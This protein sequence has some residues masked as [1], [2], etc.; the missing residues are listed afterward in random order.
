[1]GNGDY[2]EARKSLDKALA[3]NPTHKYARS[4]LAA[5]HYIRGDKGDFAA[6]E[7]EI[8][9]WDPTYGRLYRVVSELVGERQRRYDVAAEFA[10]KAL[11]IDSKDRFAYTLLGE[12]LMNLGQTDEALEKFDAGYKA[13]KTYKDVRR[14][15]WRNVLRDVIPNFEIIE[16]EH[17]RI[18]MPRAE[19]RIMR[20]Y[21]PDLLEESYETLGKKYGVEATSPTFVD[22]FDRQDDFSVRSIGSAGLPALGVC[23]GRVVTLLGPTAM[24]IGNFSWSRTT[25][26]E[27]AHVVTL[28]KSSGQVPR[29]LT[30]G[31]S[32]FEEGER[33]ERWGRDMERQLYNRWR[34]GRLLKMSEINS[35]FRGPDIMFAY[36]QGGLIAAHLQ[37]ARG[38]EVIPKMLERFGEDK[39]T[40]EVFQDVLELEL[41]RYDEMFEGYVE[42]IVGEY[43]IAPAWDDQSMDAFKER[44]KKKPEDA[45]AWIRMAWG[46]FQRK[47]GIDSGA[48]LG[49]AKE[50]AP[51]HPELVLLEGAMAARAGRDA[52]AKERFEKVIALGSDDFSARLFLANRAMKTQTDA[53]PAIEHLQAAKKCFP[54]AVGK[55]SPYLQ[56]AKI[57]RGEGD[58]KS[59]LA[60]LEA[61][62]AISAEDY[63]VRKELLRS[64]V[65]TSDWEST[66]RVCEEMVD[67]SPFGADIR[68]GAEPDLELHR[69]WA[70][71]LEK[72]GKPKERLRELQ[73]QV[74]LVGLLPEETQAEAAQL[75]DRLA[76]GRALLSGDPLDALEQAVAVLRL[77][78]GNAD[79]LMLKRRA[80]EADSGR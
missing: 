19:A 64:Y 26:H 49:K 48:A 46:Y 9:E 16:T 56:L 6:L 42:S 10:R 72:L 18:R 24:P 5:L 34:N 61:Y 36:F 39:S 47:N 15:N 74:E 76:L 2:D 60:E 51:D 59:A 32:V 65:R 23:F 21:L 17:F 70:K 3:I 77:S 75:G 45:E 7:K 73:V 53:K 68:G 63:E 80:E 13:S 67:I 54:R 35:A 20:H 38:F 14:D 27:F 11:E 57:Y 44:V 33:R 69:A 62:A 50:L 4:V 28:Q 8:L 79:A 55:N 25:W 66:A 58:A 29:W 71:A 37:Q 1:M 31:L 30:E 52:R 12:A 41:A 78:P 43:K 22:A 40:A